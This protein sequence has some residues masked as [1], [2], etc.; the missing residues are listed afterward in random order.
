MS[1]PSPPEA[2][3]RSLVDP[4]LAPALDLLPPFR[5]VGPHTLA[6]LRAT[7]EAGARLQLETAETSGASISEHLVAPLHAGAPQVRV[8]VYRPTQASGPL[9]ALLHLHGG[10]LVVG[11]PEMRHAS[12]LANVREIGCVVVS[13]DYRLAPETPYPGAL[14][15]GYAALLWLAALGDEFNIDR[16]RIAIAGESA[17]GGVA[18]CIALRARDCGK[19]A[20]CAQ[21]LSYPMLDDRT[22]DASSLSAHAGQFVWGIAANQFGWRAY[23]GHEAGAPNV[24]PYA[25]AA[26]EERLEGLPATFVGVGALDLFLEEDL[27]YAR[28]L[29]RAGVPT[30]LHVYAGA[31]HGFDVVLTASAAQAFRADWKRAAMRAF[32]CPAAPGGG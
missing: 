5:D 23:L 26:R 21:L 6:A 14:D 20:L 8:V 29:I 9:P 24:S 15:D 32:R 12:H 2:P 4:E 11:R 17:G 25:A 28:R 16:H 7:V 22:L 30:D 27:D 31:F 18:A 10:G 3:P 1:A 19:V 13:V